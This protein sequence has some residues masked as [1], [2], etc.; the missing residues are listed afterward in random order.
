[1]KEDGVP[2]GS[3]GLFFFLRFFCRL[4]GGTTFWFDVSQVQACHGQQVSRG[5][6]PIEASISCSEKYLCLYWFKLN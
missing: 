4:S 2:N 5:H 6:S 1:M 3:L